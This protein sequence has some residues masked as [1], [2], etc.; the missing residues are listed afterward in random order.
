[1]HIYTRVNSRPMCDN[2]RMNSAHIHYTLDM[3]TIHCE[4]TSTMHKTRTTLT[5]TLAGNIDFTYTITLHIYNT[6]RLHR[7]HTV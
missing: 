6:H 1:M 4:H 7:T 3:H 5:L 2:T